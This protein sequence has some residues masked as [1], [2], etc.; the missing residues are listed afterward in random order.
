MSASSGFAL[1]GSAVRLLQRFSIT[2]D[3]ATEWPLERHSDGLHIC[4]IL[5]LIVSVFILL[6]YL[7]Y[8][9]N[10]LKQESVDVLME[11]GT[12]R[13]YEHAVK[14]DLERRPKLVLEA[15]PEG[16]RRRGRPRL[17]WEEYVDG[18]ARKRGRSY[19]K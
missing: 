9:R 19:Q 16:G 17:E 13:S 10:Q 11:K 5:I 12:S 4:G 2:H 1:Q 14:M 7:K 3:T 15:R 18:L 8:I 6:F